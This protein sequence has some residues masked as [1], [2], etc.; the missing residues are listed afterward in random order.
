IVG[1][2][3]ARALYLLAEKFGAREAERIGL[4]SRCVPDAELM[5][6][7]RRVAGRVAG[8]APLTLQSVKANLND[9]LRLSFPEMLDVE[10]QRHI[11]CGLTEDA[12]EAAAA[13]LEKRT[14]SFVG[15]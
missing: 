6:E 2:A 3:R 14:P 5:G 13:F 11:G 15:R 10:A 4:V 8:F 12:R 9:S 1:P 7:V